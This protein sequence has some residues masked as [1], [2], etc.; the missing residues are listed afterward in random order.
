ML[1]GVIKQ[2][3][4]RKDD[5]TNSHRRHKELEILDLKNHIA[6]LQ[7]ELDSRDQEVRRLDK[8]YTSIIGSRRL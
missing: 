8:D 5:A 4:L 2:E 6:F 3:D 1:D 7:K